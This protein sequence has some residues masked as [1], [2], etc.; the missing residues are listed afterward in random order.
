MDHLFLDG[1]LCSS[2]I[3]HRVFFLEGN[4]QHLDSA[5]SSIFFFLVFIPH[6]YES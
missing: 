6:F 1:L 2:G 5:F 4:W 3:K